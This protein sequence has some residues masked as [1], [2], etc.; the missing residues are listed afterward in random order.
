MSEN[1]LLLDLRGEFES[2]PTCSICNQQDSVNKLIR[3]SSCDKPAHRDCCKATTDRWTCSQCTGKQQSTTRKSRCSNSRSSHASF[4][5][6]KELQL[7]RLE[8]EKLIKLKELAVER[9]FLNRKYKLLEQ[10]ESD[11]DLADSKS[12]GSTNSRGS[13]VNDWVNQVQTGVTENHGKGPNQ[14]V[15]L[16]PSAPAFINRTQG[17]APLTNENPNFEPPRFSTAAP[18]AMPNTIQ[19]SANALPST[20]LDQMG[21]VIVFVKV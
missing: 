21:T 16:D 7:K 5:L 11:D 20:T 12:R 8:E 15:G 17:T 6:R 1:N 13:Y 3:C 18:S 2:N 4:A 9:E 19:Q 14:N 10:L